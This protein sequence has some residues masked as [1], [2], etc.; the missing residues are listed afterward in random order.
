MPSCQVDKRC[1]ISSCPPLSPCTKPLHIPLHPHSNYLTSIPSICPHSKLYGKFPVTTWWLPGPSQCWV[2]RFCFIK[3]N[4][5][6]TD[7]TQSAYPE[8][9]T[10]AFTY[11]T[12][13]L[14]WY[15]ASSTGIRCSYGS[16]QRKQPEMGRLLSVVNPYVPSPQKKNAWSCHNHRTLVGGSLTAVVPR[17]L[18]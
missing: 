7:H 8:P 2:I 14:L 18:A 4:L 5:C 11:G 10:S 9:R 17:S 15:W 6:E 16:G 13:G 1:E 3:V 12:P